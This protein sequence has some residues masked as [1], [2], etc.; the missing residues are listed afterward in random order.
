MATIK[1]YVKN[2]RD[3]QYDVAMKMGVDISWSDINT[4]VILLSGYVVQAIILKTLVDSGAIT[5]AALK[6]TMDQVR[7]AV[8]DPEPGQ[9]TGWTDVTPVTGV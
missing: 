7:Q 2:I 5:D 3:T 8:Y 6:A 1:Q 4:R 9:P